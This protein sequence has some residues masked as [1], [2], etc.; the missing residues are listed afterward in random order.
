MVSKK[1]RTWNMRSSR[2]QAAK[3]D[4]SASVASSFE[5]KRK[6]W[7]CLCFSAAKSC[8]NLWAAAR[9]CLSIRDGMLLDQQCYL[10]HMMNH[11]VILWSWCLL[12]AVVVTVEAVVCWCCWYLLLLLGNIRRQHYSDRAVPLVRTWENMGKSWN[13]HRLSLVQRLDI[14][15]YSMI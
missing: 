7:K 8:P 15:W 14:V 3:A 2:K 12:F 5:R 4:R 10:E 1:C 9:A 6:K 13:M 11:H